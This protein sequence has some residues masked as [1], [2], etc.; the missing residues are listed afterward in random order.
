MISVTTR[1]GLFVCKIDFM[2]G[3]NA[4]SWIRL[5][6]LMTA[7]M[8]VFLLIA[9]LYISE[10]QEQQQEEKKLI[11]EYNQNKKDI[12]ADLNSAF[13]NKFQEW[14]MVL[15]DDLS[16]KF[17]NPEVLFDFWSA[18][19]TDKYKKILDEF[20]PTYL[21]IINK[22][23]YRE[24]IKEVRIEGHTAYWNDY[25]ASI[26]LSQA[27][28]NAVLGY[29]F[30]SPYF[31]MLPGEDKEQLKFWLTSNGLGFG[32]A[33]DDNDVFVI[34]SKSAISNKSR[35]VEFK[36]VTSSDSLVETLIKKYQIIKEE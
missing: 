20:L 28:S 22:P 14:E 12:Y 9:V 16:I 10:V 27:R 30:D 1:G 32:R 11:S 35:R 17:N 26:K 2:K 15:D 18:D 13:Q 36:I 6:D 19:L 5:S 21:S 23:E 3:S 33:I 31:T 7:L 24:N 4:S 8:M 29:I 34:N 25:M